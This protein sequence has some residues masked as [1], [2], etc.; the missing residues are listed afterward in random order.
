MEGK[1][2]EMFFRLVRVVAPDQRG[3]EVRALALAQNE[4]DASPNVRLNVGP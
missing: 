3:A 4:W 1:V 2:A